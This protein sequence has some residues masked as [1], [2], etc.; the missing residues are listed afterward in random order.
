MNSMKI[1][2]G[3]FTRKHN[4]PLVYDIATTK[5]ANDLVSRVSCDNI[6]PA[7]A[8]AINKRGRNQRVAGGHIGNKDVLA[9][10]NHGV[11]PAFL[12]WLRTH[13]F[14]VSVKRS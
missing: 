11:H 4:C 12:G 9:A 10:C 2:V 7:P 5:G 14:K 1:T 13:V 8:I 3:N 6:D